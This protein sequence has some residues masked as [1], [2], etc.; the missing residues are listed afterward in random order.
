MFARNIADV[1]AEIEHAIYLPA[2]LGAPWDIL[3]PKPDATA[4]GDR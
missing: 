2:T 4:A 3:W 1:A